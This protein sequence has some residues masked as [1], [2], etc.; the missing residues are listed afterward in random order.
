MKKV[1]SKSIGDEKNVSAAF[2]YT[3]KNIPGL[4]LKLAASN[5][6]QVYVNGEFLAYG[7]LRAA[8]GYS[9]LREYPISADEEVDEIR[10]VVIVA[11]YRINSFYTVEE[12][13][14]FAAE[15]CAGEEK[16]AGTYDFA[17]YRLDDRRQKVHRYSFQR[18]FVESYRLDE[19]REKLFG[20]VYE[21]PALEMSEVQGNQLLDTDLD[22]PLYDAVR[23]VLIEHGSAEIDENRHVFK[24]R[25]ITQIS[26][27]YKGFT[28]SELEENTIAEACRI[29]CRMDTINRAG[30]Y[31]EKGYQFFDFGRIVSGFFEMDMTVP[32]HAEVYVLFDEILG[33]EYRTRVEPDFSGPER[34][35]VP[36]R[37]ECSNVIKWSLE[38][39]AH[40]LVSFEPYTFRY[41]KVIVLTG[42]GYLE[43]FG[44]VLFENPDDNLKFTCKDQTLQKI[45]DAAKNTFRQNAVD[46]LTDCPSRERAGWLCDSYF[47]AQTE[48]FVTGFNKVEKN[49]LNNYR[50]S[51]PLP[52]EAKGMLPMCYPS[53]FLDRTY[54]PNWAMWFV[55]ELRDYKRRTGDGAFVESCR[56]RVY[57]LLEFFR[58]F[59]GK[60][61]FLEKLE[62][63]VFIEWSRANE[64][65][66]DV[67]FPTN[68]LYAAMLE[69][70]ADLYAD[71]TLAERAEKLKKDIIELSYNGE[72]F[73]DNAL[74]NEAGELVKTANT[75][76]TCQYYAFYLGIASKETFPKLYDIMF[77]EFGPKRNA[78]TQYKN[79]FAS[80][81]FMGNIMRLSYL[82][83]VGRAAQA[84]EECREYYG[85]MAERTGTLWENITPNAS[86][87]HGFASFILTLVVSATTGLAAFDRNAKTVTVI[88]PSC[89]V[90]SKLELRLPEGKLKIKAKNGKMRIRLPKGYVLIKD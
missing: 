42:G 73:V 65:T 59:E 69:C 27:T 30:S 22:E 9:N 77:D 64:F 3:C 71:E 83:Q 46:V 81:A 4:T 58:R 84:V 62:S 72:F 78:S 8:H 28:E 41:A 20:G 57:E 16:V 52:D 56:P 17:M 75:T 49:F 51:R 19:R 82:A 45:F 76:E 44:A 68:M 79:V 47:T 43:N 67:N 80:N 54:I 88:K 6:Y 31:I 13:P 11:A 7:P 74:Y 87:N 36:Y 1:W 70:V 40:H 61:G 12:E 85:Y 48:Q 15:V 24:D 25:A 89:K 10:L 35:L 50:L 37:M 55:L 66:Q 29:A 2:V 23:P 60:Y 34:P 18:T 63:W 33:E 14:F 26:E 86:C 21:Y 32:G 5:V 53:D 39:G 90:K 38:E